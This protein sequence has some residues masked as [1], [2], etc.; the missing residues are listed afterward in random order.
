MFLGIVIPLKAKSVSKSWNI[1]CQ[2][3]EMTIS[4][5]INQTDSDFI[6]VIAGHDCP[7]FIE[8]INKNNIIY[9]QVDFPEPEKENGN[10]LP[11]KLIDDKNLK[12]ISAMNVIASYDTEYVFQL[13]SDDLI[14]KN[15][16]E[17]LKHKSPFDFLTIDGGYLLFNNSHRYI[18]IGNINQF[19]GS[20]VV[21]NKKHLFFPDRA[22]MDY[23]TMIPWTK[24]RHMN[25]HKFYD[26]TPN[27]N[28]SRTSSRLISY[29]V[30][31]GDNFSDRWRDDW[32]KRLKWN[33]KPYLFGRKV[34]SD[35]SK[36]FGLDIM[37]DS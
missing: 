29:V 18:E 7:D 34:D 25:I 1:T 26:G 11:Q 37:A 13:D 28:F 17:N 36:N 22:D 16:I 24:H 21:I 14:C 3:L 30:G 20:T 15:F 2:S 31:S 12:I 10:Y 27:F 8:K 35:F 5:L 6:A 33:L 4:S 23:R 19:C 32:F 9:Y